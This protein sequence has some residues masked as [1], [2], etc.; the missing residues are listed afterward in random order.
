MDIKRFDRGIFGSNTYVISE[1][2]GKDGAVIDC[3]N[4]VDAVKRYVS[5]NSIDITHIILTHGHYDHAELIGDYRIAFPDAVTVCTAAET[6]VL[7]DPEANVSAL[8]GER[9]RYPIPDIALNDGDSLT[10]G[11]SVFEVI[12]A[13]GHT[14]GS[15]CLYCRSE[16]LMFT[17][18]VLFAHGRGRTD[19]KYGS[20]KDMRLSLEKL[21]SMDGDT[22]IYPGHGEPSRISSERE[23]Y[24]W[25][26]K[27]R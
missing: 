15:Y 19:F 25:N 18:D 21:L 17:G 11:G 8:V 3:G 4:T 9:A 12:S 7:S 1:G 26:A 23:Y 5:D 27:T 16:K 10:L 13:P 24:A 14:P 6:A 22:V 20:E 2:G